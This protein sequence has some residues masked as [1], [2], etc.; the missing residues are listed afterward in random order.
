MKR[1]TT[2]LPQSIGSSC[3]NRDSCLF[4]GRA[5]FVFNRREFT[6]TR[7]ISNTPAAIISR[8]SFTDQV[9]K[10]GTLSNIAKLDATLAAPATL[11]VGEVVALKT[12]YL[13]TEQKMETIGN[14]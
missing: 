13:T 5:K 1:K 14:K 3:E 7:A 6:Q 8:A 10:K 12:N 11:V 9:V 4:D 2:R